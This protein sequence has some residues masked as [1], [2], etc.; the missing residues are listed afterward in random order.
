MKGIPVTL[1]ILAIGFLFIS[2]CTGSQEETVYNS[3]R[4][5]TTYDIDFENHATDTN[6]Y[7]VTGTFTNE[8]TKPYT[9]WAGVT[10]FNRLN[11]PLDYQG[12]NMTLNPGETK[13]IVKTFVVSNTF[14]NKGVG[15]TFYE[16]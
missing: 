3:I 9:I 2:G 13:T 12:E 6:T 4:A 7:T 1:C 16:I 8:G 5:H 11:V 10:V 15:E 14:R